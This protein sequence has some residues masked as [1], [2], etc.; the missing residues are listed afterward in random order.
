M[1]IETVCNTNQCNGCM[2]C[3]NVCSKNAISLVDNI[4]YMNACINTEKCINCGLC[5][6]VCPNIN[7]VKKNRPVIIKQ[8]W[9]KRDIRETSSSGGLATEIMTNFVSD[10]GYVCSCSCVGNEYAYKTTKDINEIKSFSGSK[11]VKSNPKQI[12]KEILDLLINDNKVLFVGLPCHSAALQNYINE[13]YKS[14]LY[15]IDL[16]CHGTPSPKVLDRFVGENKKISNVE[17]K[18]ISFRNKNRYYIHKKDDKEIK[19]TDDYTLLFLNGITYTDNC[20]NCKFASLERCSDL[21]LGDS[22]GSDLADE[23]DRGISLVL[24][25]SEK[26]KEL[27]NNVNLELKEVN[28]DKAI[29]SNQ[30]LNHPFVVDLKKRT[31]FFK[32]CNKNRSFSKITWNLFFVS[33]LK[34]LVKKIIKYN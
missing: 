27:L 3:V 7:L 29:A 34:I 13:K 18:N 24:C 5:K 21:T 15:T 30:Q 32:L 1:N 26:G 4:E 23:K 22:W 19:Q 11:Y 9:T 17:K 28:T 31:K 14:K 33:K 12:Y 6:K 16:I 10:G 25:Q 8:G 2:A 20:Y